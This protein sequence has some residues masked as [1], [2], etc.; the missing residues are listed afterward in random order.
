MSDAI[1]RGHLLDPSLSAAGEA[2]DLLVEQP[3]A[4][5]RVERIVSPPGF[6]GADG[7]WYDQDEDEWVAVLAGAGC[8]ELAGRSEP[9]RLLPGDWLRLPAHCRHRVAATHPTVAT[10]WLAVFYPAAA[11]GKKP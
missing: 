5:V 11:A 8:L 9:I 6:S 7:A 2:F 1:R 4:G 3:E 10:V